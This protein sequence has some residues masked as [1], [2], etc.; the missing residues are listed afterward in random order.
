VL[1]KGGIHSYIRHMNLLEAIELDQ[2]WPVQE[3]LP[4]NEWPDFPE[5]E[6]AFDWNRSLAEMESGLSKS[7]LKRKNQRIAR[8]NRELGEPQSRWEEDTVSVKF[9]TLLPPRATKTYA[10]EWKEW[11]RR[12]NKERAERQESAREHVESYI[13][14]FAIPTFVPPSDDESVNFHCD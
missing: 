10:R 11:I 4:D 7:Q 12:K 9:S 13:T 14:K 6:K 1:G 2:D 8:F 5:N 3:V